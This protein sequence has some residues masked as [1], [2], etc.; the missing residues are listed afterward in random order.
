MTVIKFNKALYRISRKRLL[1]RWRGIAIDRN[2]NRPATRAR[3]AFRVAGRT[4]RTEEGSRERDSAIPTGWL[5]VLPNRVQ[6]GRLYRRNSDD[7]RRRIVVLTPYH[8]RVRFTV[9]R[10]VPPQGSA[11]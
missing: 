9:T 4:F 8:V 6:I 1:G 11:T 10:F 7:R 3:R 5:S 2:G